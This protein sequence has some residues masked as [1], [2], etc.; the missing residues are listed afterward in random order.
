MNIT[1]GNKIKELRKQRGIT[2]EQ[3]AENIG[4]SFQA[5]SKW[6]NNIALPDITLVP[7]LAGFFGVSIDEL[8]DYNLRELQEKIKK[9]C[10]EAY[11]YRESDPQKAREI[12]EEGLKK[13]PNND[14]LLN[15]LLYVLVE[16]G[17]TIQIAGKL[18][19]A[20]NEAD[21]KYDALR[22]L[23]GAYNE[24]GEYESAKAALD[25]IPELY[26]T[27][28]TEA[29]SI[30]KGYAGYEAAEKQKFVSY[31]QLL[32]MCDIISKYYESENRKDDAVKELKF[33]INIIDALRY[34]GKIHSLFET[35]AKN[36]NKEIAR[37]ENAK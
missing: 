29:A 36:F 4:I 35:Y 34:D 18:V 16:A 8:F 5:V 25:Q 20:T 17:E 1:I 15:N 23:A 9:I 32:Q 30:Y 24:K 13:Y 26:F 11:I 33:G 7:T 6:E 19:S 28:L 3:L 10:D 22:F 14:I 37:I 2:Q 12:L 21:V 27:K 31:E